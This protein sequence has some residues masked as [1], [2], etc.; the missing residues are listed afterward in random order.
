[1]GKPDKDLTAQQRQLRDDYF[2]YT[3]PN[4]R[5]SS[6]KETI[7]E[8]YHPDV[9]K[10]WFKL[11]K[12]TA[13]DRRLAHDSLLSSESGSSL[14]APALLLSLLFGAYLLRRFLS[15]RRRQPKRSIL[16]LWD[17]EVTFRH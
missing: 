13:D 3:D 10:E 4:L 14:L 16:P 7:R 8:R 11:P 2:A 6:A 15:A 9:Q 1:M 17:D 5:S 12:G